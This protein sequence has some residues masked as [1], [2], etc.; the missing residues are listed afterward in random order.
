MIITATDG[1]PIKVKSN[2]LNWVSLDTIDLPRSKLKSTFFPTGRKAR[3]KG[4]NWVRH[5]I[6]L[7][8]PYAPIYFNTK[9][10]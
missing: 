3:A 6:D 5:H 2:M 1:I 9:I 4:Q 8:V 10:D 7:V